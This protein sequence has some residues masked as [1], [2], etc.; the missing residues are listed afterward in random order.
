M[1]AYNNELWPTVTG[2]KFGRTLSAELQGEGL[3]L[4][5]GVKNLDRS[6]TCG[7]VRIEEPKFKLSVVVAVYTCLPLCN[8][9]KWFPGRSLTA[10]RSSGMNGGHIK[11]GSLA[12]EPTEG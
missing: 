10:K 5:A 9:N 6:G 4:G 3:W 1:N 2:T 12:P 7:I 8:I 11:I